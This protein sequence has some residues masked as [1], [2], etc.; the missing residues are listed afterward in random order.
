MDAFLQDQGCEPGSMITMTENAFMM[1][2]T[3]VDLTP[4]LVSGYRMLEV[5]WDN[6][7]WWALELF[8]SFGSHTTNL[9]VTEVCYFDCCVQLHV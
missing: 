7:Q 5:V 9:E 8:D 1:D 3:W 2:A 6:P 4:K